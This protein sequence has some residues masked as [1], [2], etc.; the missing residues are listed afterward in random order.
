MFFAFNNGIS[1][2]AMDS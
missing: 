1:A 2:T